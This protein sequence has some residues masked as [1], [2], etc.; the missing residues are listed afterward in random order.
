MEELQR[1]RPLVTCGRTCQPGTRMPATLSLHVDELQELAVRAWTCHSSCLLHVTAKI[2]MHVPHSSIS[3]PVAIVLRQ[4]L[5][6]LTTVPSP[7]CEPVRRTHSS[8]IVIVAVVEV[9]NV[10]AKCGL[11]CRSRQT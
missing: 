6:L 8:S 1:C 5:S 9:A 2:N 10:V 11:A 4:H 7:S 3:S